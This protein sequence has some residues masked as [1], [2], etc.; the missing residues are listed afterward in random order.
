MKFLE[1][2]KRRYA[3]FLVSGFRKI[4]VGVLLWIGW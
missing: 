4:L 3:K 2:F 1:N